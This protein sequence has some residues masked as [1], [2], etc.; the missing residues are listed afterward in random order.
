MIILSLIFVYIVTHYR[1]NCNRSLS[2]LKKVNKIIQDF[3][4]FSCLRTNFL[5]NKG[6]NFIAPRTCVYLSVV[7]ET[8]YREKRL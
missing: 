4:K 1:Y 3:D 7:V 5:M 6:N 2:T 8:D